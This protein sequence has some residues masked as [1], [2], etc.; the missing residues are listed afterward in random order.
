MR[1]IR[2]ALAALLLIAP[3]GLAQ[4]AEKVVTVGWGPYA[5]VPQFSIALASTFKEEGLEVRLVPFQ[6]GREGFEAMIGGQVDLNIMTEFPAVAGA[7]RRQPFAILAV[8]SRYNASRLITTQGAGIASPADL[9]GKRIGLPVGTNLQFM[10]DQEMA[11]ASA[12]PQVVNLTPPDLIPALLRGD[13]DAIATFASAYPAVRR[14]L[15]ERYREVP[16]TGY[17][18]TFLVAAAKP[19]LERDPAAAGAFLKALVRAEEIMGKDP[20]AAQEAVSRSV[21]KAVPLDLIR[22]DWPNYTFRVALDPA[23]V[24]LMTREGRWIAERGLVKNVEPTPDLFRSVL[25]P[26]P[27]SGVAPDRVTAQ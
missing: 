6:S 4:A 22:A 9:A 12:K 13:V 26:G 7:M 11:R 16:V 20:A 5:D 14:A 25:A 18:S 27:L 8:V 21:G 2:A 24:E 23:L 19:F 3:A 10:V 15:G 17:A 1:S